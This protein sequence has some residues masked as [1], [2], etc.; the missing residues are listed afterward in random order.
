MSVFNFQDEN[1]INPSTTLVMKAEDMWR[2][3][4]RKEIGAR[5]ITVLLDPAYAYSNKTRVSKTNVYKCPL[6]Y[7]WKT[8]TF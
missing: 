1:G 5:V 7:S 6:P 8:E 3:L 2:R 4:G